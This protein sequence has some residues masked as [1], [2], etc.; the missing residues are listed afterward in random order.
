M[1][2]WYE[3][4]MVDIAG[5]RDEAVEAVTLLAERIVARCEAI[6]YVQLGHPENILIDNGGIRAAVLPVAMQNLGKVGIDPAYTG[7]EPPDETPAAAVKKA[8]EP[9]VC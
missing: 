2:D 5:H 1:S 8:D 7:F 9:D 4:L 6:R 3:R